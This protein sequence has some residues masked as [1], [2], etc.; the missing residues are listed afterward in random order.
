[1]QALKGWRT[2]AVGLI[3]A[4]G[5]VA[6]QFLAGVNWTTVVSPTYAPVIVGAI[7]IGMRAITNTS[8]GQKS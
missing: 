5:P 7:M 2:I 4:I 1:M 8:P 3:V 6:L